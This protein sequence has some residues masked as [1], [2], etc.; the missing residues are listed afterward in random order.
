MD[1]K[2]IEDA[3]KQVIEALEIKNIECDLEQTPTRIAES[4]KE[5][6]Y[7]V[8]K[9]P[10]DAVKKLFDVENHNPIV[11]KNIDFYSV[12]EHHF[13]PF[14]GTIDLAY[15]PDKKILGLGDVYKIIDILSKRPQL[16][17]RLTEE[18]AKNIFEIAECKGVYIIVKAKHLCLSMRGEK[19]ENTQIITTA[20]YGIFED[21]I[22][23]I[24]IQN[25]LK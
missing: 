22:K 14:F 21:D 6:F 12:C 16:Q 5:L 1:I 3:F 11:Q 13:L 24:E 18:I 10:K 17:E 4:Y 25:L 8:E 20:S 2:K 15:V 23:K 19:K 9:N 7:G